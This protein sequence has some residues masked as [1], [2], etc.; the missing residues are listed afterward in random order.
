MAEPA[1]ATTE[2]PTVKCGVP[3]EALVAF[4]DRLLKNFYNNTT[5][6]RRLNEIECWSPYWVKNIA[7]WKNK[8]RELGLLN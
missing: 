8:L 7:A 2:K 1:H 6:Q 3:P 4:K 5:Y